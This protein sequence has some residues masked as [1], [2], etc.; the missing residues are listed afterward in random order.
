MT[1]GN[2]VETSVVD[3]QNTWAIGG[4]GTPLAGVTRVWAGA[5]GTSTENNYDCI[6]DHFFRGT[7]YTSKARQSRDPDNN[8]E[9]YDWCEP[10]KPYYYVFSFPDAPG[11]VTGL[12][13]LPAISNLI[14]AINGHNFQASVSL[15]EL[16]ETLRYI[17]DKLKPIMKAV[18]YLKRGDVRRAFKAVGLT[19]RKG[20]IKKPSID[21]S[22]FDFPSRWLEFRYAI[23]PMVHDINNALEYLDSK[24]GKPVSA[25]IRKGS[26]FSPTLSNAATLMG[27]SEFWPGRTVKEFAVAGVTLVEDFD[28]EEIDLRN[29]YT[30]VWE[31]FP[32]SFLIDWAIDIGKYLRARYFFNFAKIKAGYVTS[33]L[34][35]DSGF[36]NGGFSPPLPGSECGDRVGSY[37]DSYQRVD[38]VRRRQLGAEI[39]RPKFKNPLTEYEHWVRI[40]DSFSLISQM[41]RA[42]FG[43]KRRRMF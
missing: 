6:Y 10:Y 31:I 43:R 42:P 32:G 15:A 34:K 38:I 35:Y 20:K 41:G 11:V 40:V 19:W 26:K 30:A 28:Y 25:R 3:P 24:I 5:D 22:E 21:V 1:T 29:P 27:A 37:K 36:Y 9:W 7:C 33:Y 12:A 39:P 18:R 23:T 4:I 13:E 2:K 17:Y 16:P 8:W 14:S